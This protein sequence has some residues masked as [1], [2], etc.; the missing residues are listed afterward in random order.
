[1]SK[2]FAEL[3]LAKGVDVRGK[4][5]AVKEG[6]ELKGGTVTGEEEKMP[7]FVKLAVVPVVGPKDV[8]PVGDGDGLSPPDA[9]RVSINAALFPRRTK[10]RVC[11]GGMRIANAEIVMSTARA[12]KAAIRPDT[13]RI[14]QVISDVVAPWHGSSKTCSSRWSPAWSK[15]GRKANRVDYLG[16]WSEFRFWSV[17]IDLFDGRDVDGGRGRLRF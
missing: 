17:E 5:V 14:A 11:R 13:R 3:M 12:R 4:E 2:E 10:G 15:M 6:I 16:H 8:V 1:M 7:V 9:W